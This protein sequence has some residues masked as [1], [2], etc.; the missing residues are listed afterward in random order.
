MHLEDNNL[1]I[2]MPDRAMSREDL[3]KAL[4]NQ[5]VRNVRALKTE[6]QDRVVVEGD[7]EV[8]GLEP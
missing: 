2:G 8:V 3:V 6:F 7:D 4:G 1:G 5:T